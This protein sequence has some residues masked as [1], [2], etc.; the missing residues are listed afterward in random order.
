MLGYSEQL[1]FLQVVDD[2]ELEPLGGR[3]AVTQ[4]MVNAAKATSDFY[5]EN[6]PTNGI[7][8]WDTGAPDWLGSAIT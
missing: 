3:E 1:E 8:Y 2:G 5:I 7:P 6:S 4:M